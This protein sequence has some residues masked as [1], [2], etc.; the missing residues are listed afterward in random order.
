MPLSKPQLAEMK[1]LI[2]NAEAS[3]KDALADI[4]QAKR[5]GVDVKELEDQAR[6]LREKIRRMKVVYG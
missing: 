1:T 6:E 2:S 3:L 5:A 4:A